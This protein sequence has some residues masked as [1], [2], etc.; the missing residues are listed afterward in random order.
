MLEKESCLDQRCSLDQRHCCW[1][2]WWL[3]TM[4]SWGHWRWEVFVWMIQCCGELSPG[5]T[6]DLNQWQHQ[7]QWKQDI[8]W[9]QWQQQ[10]IQLC[11]CP[12]QDQGS[13][14]TSA[15][16][17]ASSSASQSTLEH[18][19]FPVLKY[20]LPQTAERR[21]SDLLIH[22]DKH[23]FLLFS[24]SPGVASSLF[25]TEMFSTLVLHLVQQKLLAPWCEML[26]GAGLSSDWVLRL[27]SVI[28]WVVPVRLP[29]QVRCAVEGWLWEH[30]RW[31]CWTADV[32]WKGE[33]EMRINL[34]HNNHHQTKKS[35]MKTRPKH[36]SYFS[37]TGLPPFKRNGRTL[38]TI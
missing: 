27:K 2:S 9:P 16:S 26:A 23:L 7:L 10:H 35:W 31:E 32:E 1:G 21:P 36:I 37:L 13:L 8:G 19:L 12:S 29:G 4:I 30:W 25:C 34:K 3:E 38:D 24:F 14:S 5:E 11:I 22:Q 15:V 33:R 28:R 20:F 17:S 18:Q 6:S